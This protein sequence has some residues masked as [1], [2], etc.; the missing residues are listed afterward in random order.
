[1]DKRKAVKAVEKIGERL[2]KYARAHDRFEG[3]KYFNE[4]MVNYRKFESFLK[5]E[6]AKVAP[7]V[8]QQTVDEFSK[9]L[10]D[11][12]FSEQ[13]YQ[14][15]IFQHLQEL[16]L[17]VSSLEFE[18]L[19]IPDE[20]F[21]PVGKIK[22][23][24]GKPARDTPV[25]WDFFEFPNRFVLRGTLVPLTVGQFKATRE[26]ARSC[27][28]KEPGISQDEL[29]FRCRGKARSKGNKGR[30]IWTLK[31]CFGAGDDRK[32]SARNEKLRELLFRENDRVVS[33]NENAKI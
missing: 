21:S 9:K 31:R 27:A 16:S 2:E 7:V 24:T 4:A 33:L 3:G 30:K 1:M 25:G 22:S 14:R 5:T 23:A 20:E 15:Q 6:L 32:K 28:L 19:E 12:Q 29:Y 11:Q 17:L 10:S 18:V 8:R 26:V 13:N